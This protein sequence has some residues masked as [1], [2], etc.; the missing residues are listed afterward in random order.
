M[1]RII[2]ASRGSRKI[3]SSTSAG[4]V[5]KILEDLLVDVE[6]R[7]NYSISETDMDVLYDAT[8]ILY[9]MQSQTGEYDRLAACQDSE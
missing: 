9:N 5:A 8:T 4:D 3:M 7:H 2:Q 1:I 6:T